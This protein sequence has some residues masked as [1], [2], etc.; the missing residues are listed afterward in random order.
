MQYF[1][2]EKGKLLFLYIYSGIKIDFQMKNI[3][4]AASLAL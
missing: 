4:D 1:A 2:T 3:T